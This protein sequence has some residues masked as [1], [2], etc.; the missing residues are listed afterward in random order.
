MASVGTVENTRKR[1]PLRDYAYD[2]GMAIM[3]PIERLVVRTS[4]VDTTPML[5]VEQF[6][7]ARQLEAGWKDIRAELDAVL[8][9][10]SDLP[11]FHEITA[12]VADI[13]TDD[14]WK[15]FFFYGYGFRADAN[16]RRCPNTDELLGRIPGL[17]TA[18]F[19]ILEPGKHIPPHRGPW[20]GVIRYHL[21]LKI[22]DPEKCAIVVGGEEAHWEEGQ[23]LVFDDAYEHSAWNDSS[24]VRVVLF[25]DILRPCRPP[26]SW[27]NK[28]VIKGVAYSPFV[29][30]AKRKHEQWE[31]EYAARH[32]S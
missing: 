23:S 27:A 9:T 31:K 16:C 17:T 18:F 14:N 12:D 7:W 6:P 10:R 21:G 5:P 26:G 28:A 15:T 4:L 3:G 13:S 11:A 25:V 24:D 1:K 19:S 2:V 22:P 32:P 30:D 29:R 8:A 20:R